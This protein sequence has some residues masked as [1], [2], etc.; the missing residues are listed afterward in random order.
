MVRVSVF[1]EGEMSKSKASSKHHLDHR[2]SERWIFQ[3]LRE[4]SANQAGV[5]IV[6]ME[7]ETKWQV[8]SV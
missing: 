8:T 4:N 3:P 2:G 6:Y 7:T 5:Q 1:L